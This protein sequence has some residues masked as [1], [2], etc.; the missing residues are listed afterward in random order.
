MRHTIAHGLDAELTRRVLESAFAHYRERYARH[1]PSLDW[2]GQDRAR[3]AFQVGGWT[4]GGT[5]T[6]QS[7][8]IEVHMD[9][10][11]VFRPLAGKARQVIEAEVQ[12]WLERVRSGGA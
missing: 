10:P 6:L 12:R 11:L 3:F 7:G 8:A 4:L 1:A 2:L 9:V 5:L